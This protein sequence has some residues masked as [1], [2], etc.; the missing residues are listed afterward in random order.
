[1]ADAALVGA[2]LRLDSNAILRSGDLLG[3]LL[4]TFVVSQLRAELAVSTSRP[5][6]YHVR[7]QQGRFV[8]DLLAELGGGRVVAI[9]VK[10]SSAPTNDDARHLAG[11]RDRAEEASAAG[12]VLHTG[13][14]AYPLGERIVAAPI[15]TL[16]A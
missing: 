15:S 5:R 16:W 7:Q 12:V 3:R 8:I 6:L 13:P 9:E 4:D 10:A 2:I 14:R 11:L 1:M